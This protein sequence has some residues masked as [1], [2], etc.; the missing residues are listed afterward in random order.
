VVVSNSAGISLG[1]DLTFTT[2]PLP[3]TGTTLSATGITATNAALN[4]TAN[5]NGASPQPISNTG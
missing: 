5:P 4:G 3:P 2:Q 1:G